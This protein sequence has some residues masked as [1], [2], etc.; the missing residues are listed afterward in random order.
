MTRATL[1][2]A[3]FICLAVIL[4][5]FCS[6]IRSQPVWAEDEQ[7]E[8]GVGGDFQDPT[9]VKDDVTSVPQGVKDLGKERKP[10]VDPVYGKWWFWAIAVA[11]AGA[12]AVA[13]VYPMR[14]KAPGCS[15]GSYPLGCIGD[16]R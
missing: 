9:I 3:R 10:I 2:K 13:A 6:V 15:A 12:W 1:R 5:F 4:A 14:S 11:T 8:E 16:G 7:E